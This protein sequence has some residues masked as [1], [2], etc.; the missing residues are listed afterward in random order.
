MKKQTVFIVIFALL[1]LLLMV[2][3][4]GKSDPDPVTVDFALSN[5]FNYAPDD[6]LT[7]ASG[8]NVTVNIDNSASALDHSFLL[9]PADI[10]VTLP[11]DELKAKALGN[12]DSG[13][14]A[15]GGSDTFTFTAP[16]V[17]S[18]KFVCAVPGHAVGGM[19]GDLTVTE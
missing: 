12:I 1:S 19:V 15:A 5:E 11:S 3:C 13:I 10:D 4:G 2:A 6:L 14:I 8:A 18:Y 17:G 16:S 7:I 9:V